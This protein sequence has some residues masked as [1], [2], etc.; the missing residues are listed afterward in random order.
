MSRPLALKQK[1]ITALCKGAKAAGC[2]AEVK[3]GDVFVRLIPNAYAQAERSIDDTAN[4]EAFDT[5]DEYL[6]WRDRS[7]AREN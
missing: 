1:Q 7:G 4:P 6:A 2:I 3:I 5:L